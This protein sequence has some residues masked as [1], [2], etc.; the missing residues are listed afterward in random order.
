MVKDSDGKVVGCHPTK[1]KAKKQLAALYANEGASMQT[2]EDVTR[3]PRPPRDNIVRAIKPG[4]EFRAEEPAEGTLGTLE[5]HFAVFDQ[6]TE[7]HSIFEG[8]FLER[9]APGSFTKT[10]Q[11]NRS[12]MRVL[13]QHGSDPQIGDKV[14]GPIDVLEEDEQGARY[15]VPLLD[16]SYN[17][18]LEPGLRHDLYGASFRFRVMKEDLDREPKR[19]PYNPDGLPERTIREVQVMEFGPVT[20][21]A[22]AGATAGLR[23]MTDEFLVGR[24]AADPEQLRQLLAVARQDEAALSDDGAGVDHSDGDSRESPVVPINQRTIRRRESWRLTA[25]PQPRNWKLG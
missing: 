2:Q 12:D 23:S 19:S 10:F 6:W 14:L 1:E 13:F 8:D 25:S 15:E 7:I 24:F 18:D 20:F 16:T 3:T 17:R 5:G 4:V 22:Y 11:E 9:I 21:P